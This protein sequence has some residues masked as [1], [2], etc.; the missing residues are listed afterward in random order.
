MGEHTPKLVM[1]YL[2]VMTP[3]GEEGIPCDE[4]VIHLEGDEDSEIEIKCPRAIRLAQRIVN[5]CNGHDDLITAL[6]RIVS[7]EEKNVTKYAQ[8]IAREVLA[9]ASA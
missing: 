6:R 8:A 7:L 3:N 1:G 9:K 5:A 2:Y 4:A